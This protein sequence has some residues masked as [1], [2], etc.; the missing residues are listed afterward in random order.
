MFAFLFP[1]DKM[2]SDAEYEIDDDGGGGGKGQK[3]VPNDH[4]IVAGTGVASEEEEDVYDDP[5][6]IV[7]E[8]GNDDQDDEEVQSNNVVEGENVQ[9][10]NDDD[11]NSQSSDQQEVEQEVIDEGREEEDDEDE[12]NDEEGGGGE[13]P[14]L[15][16]QSLVHEF[17]DVDD[18]DEPSFEGFDDNEIETSQIQQDHPGHESDD[19]GMDEEQ[20]MIDQ[21]EEEDEDQDHR[22]DEN[23]EE[24][25]EDQME[26]DQNQSNNPDGHYSEED[27][28][29]ENGVYKWKDY[30]DA[31][32]SFRWFLF[33]FRIFKLL[34]PFP[35]DASILSRRVSGVQETLRAGLET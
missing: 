14:G 23:Q 15:P 27:M 2:S 9:N 1:S 30:E 4:A 20:L 24:G 13:G 32:V 17:D 28:L 3:D 33:C 34:S 11:G 16:L 19:N 8:V 31:R 5:L 21:E 12:Q 18:D 22:P 25:H 6:P 7:N 26:I 35:Q 29:D 10:Q